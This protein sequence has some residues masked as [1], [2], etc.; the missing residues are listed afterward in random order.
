MSSFIEAWKYGD[1]C[2]LNHEVTG[3]LSF[4]SLMFETGCERSETFYRKRVASLTDHPDLCNTQK[5]NPQIYD[6]HIRWHGI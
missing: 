5:V 4:V 6:Y 3:F 2:I 1:R